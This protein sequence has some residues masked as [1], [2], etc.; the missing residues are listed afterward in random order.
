MGREYILSYVLGFFMELISLLEFIIPRKFLYS[1]A[2]SLSRYKTKES[3]TSYKN[4]VRNINLCFLDYSD[5]E[6]SNIIED[7]ISN[8]GI[9]FLENIRSWHRSDKFIKDMVSVSN[10]EIIE[11][12]NN[13]GCPVIILLPHFTH[14]FFAI[15]C[16]RILTPVSGIRKQQKSKVFEF[17][18]DRCFNK[19]NIN[20]IL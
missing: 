8:H 3:S 16:I 17:Y 2:S 7:C 18:Y 15:R 1:A 12:Y 11:K 19:N 5:N 20:D 14:M 4:V 13:E 10:F 9:G 6:K